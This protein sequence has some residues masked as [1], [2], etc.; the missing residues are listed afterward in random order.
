M[1]EF[2]GTDT[3][4][5]YDKWKLAFEDTINHGKTGFIAT[6]QG[7]GYN[8][9]DAVY[10]DPTYNELKHQVFSAVVLGIDKVLFWY[11]EWS[12]DNVKNLVRQ[13]T[14][15]EQQI[16]AEMNNGVTN[17][18]RIQVS[19]T[20]RNKLVYRFGTNGSRNIILAVNIANRTSSS[21]AVLSNVRFLLPTG[22]NISTVTV[23][24]EG[25]T[26]PVTNGSFTDT[27]QKFEVHIYEFNS[28]TPTPGLTV[29]PTPVPSYPGDL[30][31]DGHINNA[32]A[33]LIFQNWFG[34]ITGDV[35]RDS[36]VNSLDFGQIL[37]D[38]G[39]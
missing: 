25:R 14:L 12:N 30:N 1:N 22:I 9:N 8:N 17:D 5:Q 26:L 6:A 16:G 33:L 32:D 37:K 35:Y 23:I 21:G 4:T 27:F 31:H 2:Y 29:T 36:K 15:L 28:S 7:F 38:W 18:S 20:D 34:N 11:D 24:D 19:E 39:K 3:R 13:M 10:R